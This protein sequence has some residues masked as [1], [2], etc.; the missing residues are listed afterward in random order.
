MS[1]SKTRVRLRIPVGRPLKGLRREKG[2]TTLGVRA[3]IRA[4]SDHQF[5]D[6]VPTYDRGTVGISQSIRAI[7][8][9]DG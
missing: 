4:I 6:E 9:W 3:T 2:R 5:E 8:A 1:E 7:C